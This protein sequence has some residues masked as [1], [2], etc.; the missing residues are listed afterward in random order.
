MSKNNL[1]KLNELIRSIPDSHAANLSLKNLFRNVDD[2]FYFWLLTEGY[3]LNPTLREL[4]PTMP[5]EQT[6]TNFTGRSGYATL[7]QAFLAFRLFKKIINNHCKDIQSC[8]SI[9]DFGCGWG[10][11]VRFF[12]KDIGAEGLYGVDCF[13]EVITICKNSNLRCT[14]EM[15]DVMPPTHFPDN[16]FDA[17]YLYSVFSHLSEEAHMAWLLEFKRILKPGGIVIATTRPRHFLIECD[18]LR[19]NKD[20]KEFQH[21]A[22]ASFQNIKECLSDYDNGRF[23]HSPTGG[24]GVLSTSFYGETAIPKKYAMERWSKHFSLVDFMYDHEH[25][26]FDQNVIIAKK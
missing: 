25:K 6:Q 24:G 9:L 12:L 8:N 4:L 19:K 14:F 23:C 13:E 26:S 10:R 1:E 15:I 2:D 7:S 11:I 16:F 17:I 22:V 20:V 5:D 3:S 18:A 21:G